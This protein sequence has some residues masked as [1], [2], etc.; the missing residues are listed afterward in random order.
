MRHFIYESSFCIIVTNFYPEIVLLSFVLTAEE[1]YNPVTLVLNQSH[2]MLP[3]SSA[4]LWKCLM[5]ISA[6]P[7]ELVRTT[8]E[9]PANGAKMRIAALM[10]FIERMLDCYKFKVTTILGF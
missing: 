7:L 2:G 4:G 8:T 10:T 6:V 1:Q 9:S 3:Y 5:L